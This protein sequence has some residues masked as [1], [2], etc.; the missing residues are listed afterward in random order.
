MRAVKHAW[1]PKGKGIDSPVYEVVHR[2]LPWSY[3]GRTH[4]D[5]SN[6]TNDFSFSSVLSN[7]HGRR[8]YEP[9]L[10]P[11]VVLD[12]SRFSAWA[13]EYQNFDD[14]WYTRAS[15]SCCAARRLTSATPNMWQP[16]ELMHG[17]RKAIQGA[18]SLYVDC[19]SARGGCLFA[20][21]ILACYPVSRMLSGLISVISSGA[22]IK[23]KIHRTFE[24]ECEEPRCGSVYSRS[25]L[26]LLV[27][28]ATP[29]RQ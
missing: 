16:P 2:G 26:V 14:C 12:V 29:N 6:P 13:R 10:K 21:R 18:S 28:T 22:R 20:A 19:R 15:F 8:C 17:T 5:I 9:D 11:K 25:W 1:P 7:L 3:R 23:N 4:T 27:K 24:L